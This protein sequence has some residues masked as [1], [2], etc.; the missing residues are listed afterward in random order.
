MV[1]FDQTYV[2]E[3]GYEHRYAQHD[4]A[5]DGSTVTCAYCGAEVPG[6]DDCPTPPEGDESAWAE[7]ATGHA[8]DCEWVR[9]RAHRRD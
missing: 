4:H 3:Q 7:I 9:T 2:D 5:D 1:T 6:C 8:E